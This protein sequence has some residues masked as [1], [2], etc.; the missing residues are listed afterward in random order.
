ML[1]V[2]IQSTLA[3][4]INNNINTCDYDCS[5]LAIWSYL[6]VP[7]DCEYKDI[8]LVALCAT[9]TMGLEDYTRLQRKLKRKLSS[10]PTVTQR[11]GS[12]AKFESTNSDSEH[13]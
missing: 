4:I 11:V 1:Q 13:C 7:S 8:I 10:L 3:I 2:S 6:T 12:R 9:I 5:Y